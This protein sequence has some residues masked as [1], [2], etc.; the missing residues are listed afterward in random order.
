MKMNE[1]LKRL[2][3]PAVVVDLDIAD[4]NIE[5]MYRE[6]KAFGISHRPHIKTHR[7]VYFAKKQM[8]AGCC[9]VTAA[10]L[11]EAEVMAQGGISDIFVAYPIIGEDKIQRLLALA[12][13]VKISTIVNSIKG[14][15]DLSEAFEKAGQKLP[16]LIE[17]DGGLNRGGLKPGEP[18]LLFAREIR[19]LPGIAIKGLMYYGGLI[20]NS[21]DRAEVEKYA[22]KEHDELIETAGLLEQDGFTMEVLS[23]GSS[24]SGKVPAVLEGIT[25]IRSGHYIFNDC[26][27]L[28]AGLATPE[29]CA[30][31]VI[32]TVVSKPDD[33]VVI[34]DVGTKSLTSDQCHY[35]KGFGYV[36]DF[37]EIEIYNLN[38]EHAF[39]RTSGK[40]PLQVGDKISIIPNHACVVTNLAEKIY[41]FRNG[42]LEREIAVEARCKSV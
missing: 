40:N 14:A 26:G 11:G 6:A 21:H 7:S 24:F 19:N 13:K 16:V 15:Q 32:T 12:R 31:N 41:G 3:T 1:A 23:A 37:P 42:R 34:C 38:E 39:L 29:E 18:T 36:T 20:Y 27:Q 35:R 28:D 2:P 25:E 17:V 22:K 9:G 5:K 4:K 8:E 33:H 30:L 10:K